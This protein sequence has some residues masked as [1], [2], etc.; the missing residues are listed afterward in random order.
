MLLRIET[1]SVRIAP[2]WIS[3]LPICEAYDGEIYVYVGSQKV[4]YEP[5]NEWLRMVEIIQFLG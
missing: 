5:L 3:T 2:V 4:R 1:K